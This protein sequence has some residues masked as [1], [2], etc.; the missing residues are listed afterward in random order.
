M[1]PFEERVVAAQRL[2]PHGLEDEEAAH[3]VA[4]DHDAVDTGAGD[5]IEGA[6]QPVGGEDRA[7]LVVGVAIPGRGRRP[8]EV[9]RC[10]GQREVVGKL[11]LAVKPFGEGVVVAMHEDDRLVMPRAAELAV[12]GGHERLAIAQARGLERDEFGARVDAAARPGDRARL[13]L[14]RNRDDEPREAERRA[15]GP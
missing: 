10:R 13:P 5:E 7:L 1:Q 4:G 2:D 3:G 9:H 6:R 15:P 14:G 11:R 12:D 8:G